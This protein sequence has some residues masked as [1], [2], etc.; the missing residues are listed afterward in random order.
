VKGERVRAFLILTLLLA[1]MSTIILHIQPVKAEPR[2]II[3]PDDYAKIQWAVGNASDGD[4]I[5]VRSGTY[6]EHLT[7]KKAISLIGENRGT[8]IIDGN[9][10]GTVVLIYA[11]N[12]TFGGFTVQNSG[13]SWPD[14]GIR[15][16]MGSDNTVDN[17]IV[18]NNDFGI[19][20]DYSHRNTVFNNTVVSNTNIGISIDF[21]STNNNVSNN[22]ASQNYVD[23]ICVR[24]GSDS[25][26]VS[27]NTVALNTYEYSPYGI[28]VRDSSNNKVTDNN[29]TAHTFNIILER[30]APNT[31]ITNNWLKNG[32]YGIA[33]M[34]SSNCRAIGNFALNNTVGFYA[35]DSDSCVIS[36][37]TAIKSSWYGL[38]LSDC[39][40][41]TFVNNTIKDSSCG[42]TMYHLIPC[43]GEPSNKTTGNNTIF[44]NNFINNTIQA[45]LT[46]K[47]ELGYEPPNKWDNGY[48]SGG[49]YWSD[50]KGQDLYHGPYQNLTGSDGIGDT[51][52]VIDANNTDRF[53]LMAL[54]T[55]FDAGTWNGVSCNVDLVSNSTVS[56]FYFN[57]AE[58]PFISFNVTGSS[59]TKGFSRIAIPKQLLWV[60]PP[61]QWVVLVGG[62]TVTPTVTEDAN[63]TYLYFTYAHST[64]IVQITGTNVVPE[65]PTWTPMLLTFIVLTV[66]IAITKR[67]LPKTPKA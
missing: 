39:I 22:I 17:N 25:N 45:Y 43:V 65:F 51:P 11:R 49:N 57:P 23:G 38:R 13:G 44:N 47:D 46:C 29:V 2:T 67:R 34:S 62:V 56:A 19:R 27:R 40:K 58:G 9:K 35:G 10:T 24:L 14:T 3:V 12:C 1:G 15:I 6:Y 41:C 16:Y 60:K 54:F 37:N 50:Y 30:N 53:P 26:T 64:K 42:I 63:Y 55:M 61:A 20:V 52:Y 32:F 48:P 5:F 33:I 21:G 18:T 28:E 8:T 7:I 31:I 4:T 59:G 66:A 36:S